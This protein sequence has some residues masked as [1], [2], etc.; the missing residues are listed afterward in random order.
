[1]IKLRCDSGITSAVKSFVKSTGIDAEIVC[2]DKY[3]ICI[4]SR[5]DNDIVSLLPPNATV[6]ANGDDHDLL[7]SLDGVTG[8][9]ITCGLSAVSTIT[10]SSIED[11]MLVVCLQRAVETVYGSVV[12]LQ[13]LPVQLCGTPLDIG[14]IILLLGLGIICGTDISKIKLEE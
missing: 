9:V 7:R 5:T 4:L 11:G 14:S 10:Y 2:D 3:D 13:E 12:G 1:M 6:L 8:T